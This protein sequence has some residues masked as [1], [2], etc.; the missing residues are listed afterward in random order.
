MGTCHSEKIR[1]ALRYKE[2]IISQ[3]EFIYLTIL[4]FSKN[5]KSKNLLCL[6]FKLY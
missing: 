1:Y 6:T 4:L 2:P 5:I 3:N